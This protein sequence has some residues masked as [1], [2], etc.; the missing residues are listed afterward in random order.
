MSGPADPIRVVIDTNVLISALLSP[1][2]V[3]DLVL[4]VIRRRRDVVL[5]DQ[6]ILA[7]YRSVLVR[8]K[9]SFPPERVEALASSLLAVGRDV[10][11][12]EPWPGGLLDGT[13]RMFVEVA[14][15][16][17]AEVLVTG[18]VKHYPRQAGFDVM[19]PTALLGLLEA[20]TPP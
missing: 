19:G 12:I 15:A 11:A 17:E 20:C 18:N 13:D 6:R 5:Y 9:F 2:R 10:G 7:E 16:G 4:G 14:I 3:P 1:G 8:P